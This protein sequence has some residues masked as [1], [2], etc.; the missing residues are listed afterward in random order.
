MRLPSNGIAFGSIMSARRGSLHRPGV[1][2]I[3]MRSRL[4]YDL[5]EHD[6]AQPVLVS[7]VVL[8]SE[9]TRLAVMAASDNVKRPPSK[10]NGWPAGHATRYI[11]QR[12]ISRL[13]SLI[14]WKRKDSVSHESSCH[15]MSMSCLTNRSN[16]A[17]GV[18]PSAGSPLIAHLGVMLQ[19]VVVHSDWV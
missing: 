4:E 14:L 16:S 10:M 13:G 6:R 11:R 19:H 3:S 15:S 9:E 5:G 18:Y 17:M 8:F 12:F 7:V 2:A 1:D